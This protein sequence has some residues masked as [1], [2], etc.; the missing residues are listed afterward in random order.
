MHVQVIARLMS[1]MLAWG[2][3]R[4]VMRTHGKDTSP[5]GRLWNPLD[6][7]TRTELTGQGILVDPFKPHLSHWS[8]V[9]V[10]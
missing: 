5:E 8:P 7:Q 9:A 10:F 1:R 4:I 3:A 2:S 6:T